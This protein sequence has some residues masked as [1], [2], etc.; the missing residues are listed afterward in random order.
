LPVGTVTKVG[1]GKDLFLNIKIKPAANLSKLEE[2]LVLVEKQERQASAEDTTHVRAADILAQR[3]PSVPDKPPAETKAG[4]N[5]A[6]GSTKPVAA[7]AGPKPIASGPAQAAKK[8]SGTP[9]SAAGSNPDAPKSA[10]AVAAPKAP[11][12]SVPQTAPQS[13]SQPPD[14]GTAPQ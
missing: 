3:L 12:P 13:T 10:P 11:K 4:E 2:V 7:T 5:A 8:P 6:A 1:S 14:D 9:V